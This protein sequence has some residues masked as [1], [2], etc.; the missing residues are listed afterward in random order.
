VRPGGVLVYSVCSFEPEETDWVVQR[1]LKDNPGFTVESAAGTL[2][3]AVVDANGFMR[4]LPHVHVVID[5]EEGTRLYFR[6][7]RRFGLMLVVGDECEL[8][9]IGIEPLGDDFSGEFLWQVTRRHRRAAIKAVLMDQREIAGVGNIYANECL[10]EAGVRPSRRSGRV[11]RAQAT[12]IA[13]RL[14]AILER[15]I[16]SRGSSLLDYRDADGN[17]GEFQRSLSVYEREGEPCRRCGAV[18]RR[19]AVAGRSSFYCPRCQR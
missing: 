13:E 18:V 9:E 7:P 4:M 2:P 5:L 16:A 10:F 15:A 19:S 8:G 1:F 6:D 11:T 14:R 12:S 3:E 17:R